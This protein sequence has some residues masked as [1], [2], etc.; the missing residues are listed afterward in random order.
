MNKIWH[1]HTIEQY[2][3]SKRNED[4]THATTW[5][6][7]D[8]IMLSQ[9]RQSQHITYCMIPFVLIGWNQQI[10]RVRM[11]LAFARMQM[12]VGDDYLLIGMGILS[13]Y[14]KCSKSR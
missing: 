10:Y 14:W 9:R 4:P 13:E 7:Y 8:S 3:S 5:M 12:G 2:L 11:Q 1:I 6:N